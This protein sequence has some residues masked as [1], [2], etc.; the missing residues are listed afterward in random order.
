V[1]G[2][3]RLCE[4]ERENQQLRMQAEFLKSSCLLREPPAVR[5]TFIQQMDAEKA[6]PRGVHVLLA[7]RVPVGVLQTT[8]VASKRSLTAFDH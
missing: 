2:R 8:D 1:S 6:Y 3:A 7:G 4:L 5:F